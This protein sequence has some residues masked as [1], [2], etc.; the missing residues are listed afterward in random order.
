MTAGGMQTEGVSGISR[1]KND[2]TFI[3]PNIGVRLEGTSTWRPSADSESKS[4]FEF[5]LK[6][7]F[8]SVKAR[9]DL[10]GVKASGVAG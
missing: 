10:I 7:K 5:R 4:D 2:T 3:Q 9:C 8:L 1:F 6:N